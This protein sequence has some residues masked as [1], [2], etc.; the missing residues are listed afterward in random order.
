MGISTAVHNQ[1]LTTVFPGSSSALVNA[2]EASSNIDDNA[3]PASIDAK[4]SRKLR[5]R[6]ERYV[7]RAARTTITIG[8]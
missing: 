7:D 6:L 8:T 2:A 5:F 3:I 4:S 1:I